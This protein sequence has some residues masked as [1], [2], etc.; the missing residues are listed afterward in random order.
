[1]IGSRRLPLLMTVACTFVCW[2]ITA[3]DSAAAATSDN[4]SK[5][6]DMMLDCAMRPTGAAWLSHDPALYSDGFLRFSYLRERPRKLRDPNNQDGDP[7][8]GWPNEDL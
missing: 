3:R 4:S 2:P 5:L 8:F 6:I 7:R 1:M